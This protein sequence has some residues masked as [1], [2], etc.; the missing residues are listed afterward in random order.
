MPPSLSGTQI[1]NNR[2]QVSPRHEIARD[3]YHRGAAS[4][5]MPRRSS[6]GSQPTFVH[7]ARDLLLGFDQAGDF[8]VLA[9]FGEHVT[10]LEIER[11]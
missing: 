10:S 7:Y 6:R 3:L 1:R 4:F 11:E 9:Q 5:S 2:Q 8:E